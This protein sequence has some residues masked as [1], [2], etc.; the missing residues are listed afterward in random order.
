MASTDDPR[1]YL[2]KLEDIRV[3]D[4]ARFEAFQQADQERRDLIADILSKYTD[5]LEDHRN[6]QIDYNT[7]QKS[8]RSLYRESELKDRE[9]ADMKLE[10]V[11]FC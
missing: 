11:C 7:L 1:V 8:N 4:A 5:L 9:L 2:T 10:Q 3:A 6:L